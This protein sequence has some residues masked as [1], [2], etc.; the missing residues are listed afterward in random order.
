MVLSKAV[1]HFLTVL[2]GELIFS[3]QVDLE[4]VLSFR[5][6]VSF[7]QETQAKLRSHG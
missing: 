2:L 7:I 1:K 6:N 3:K 5:K 4:Y